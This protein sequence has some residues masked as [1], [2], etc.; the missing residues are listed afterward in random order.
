MKKQQLIKKIRHRLF[1][2]L[3]MIGCVCAVGTAIGCHAG[4]DRAAALLRFLG[5]PYT[6]ECQISQ[7]DSPP[8]KILYEHTAS[9]DRFTFLSEPLCGIVFSYDAESG[10]VNATADGVEIPMGGGICAVFP[11]L[12]GPYMSATVLDEVTVAV[13]TWR[14][15]TEEDG[16]PTGFESPDGIR[17]TVTS[18]QP[19]SSS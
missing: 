16:T 18:F 12:S 4:T 10:N 13:D 11:F 9:G 2:G 5:A 17:I 6:M 15:T 14:I 8:R 19:S 3:L 1:A 7:Y